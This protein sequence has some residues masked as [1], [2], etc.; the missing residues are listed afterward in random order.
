MRFHPG[1]SQLGSHANTAL[2]S[3]AVACG[4]GSYPKGSECTQRT[5]LVIKF[6]DSGL[7]G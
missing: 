5:L 4:E 6:Y 3:L 2:E 7:V 1:M